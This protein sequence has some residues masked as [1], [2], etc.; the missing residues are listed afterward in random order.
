M[1]YFFFLRK[2]LC[3]LNLKV[4]IISMLNDIYAYF[5]FPKRK[6]MKSNNDNKTKQETV[7]WPNL[8]VLF[9]IFITA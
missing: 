9:F 6:N 1:K 4:L 2:M 7:C 8:R 5:N 3:C